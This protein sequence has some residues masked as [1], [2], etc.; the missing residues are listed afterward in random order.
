[1]WLPRFVQGDSWRDSLAE[2]MRRTHARWLTRALRTTP[3]RMH[4]IPRRRVDEGGFDRLMRT[5]AGRAWADRWW[6]RAFDAAD[7]HTGR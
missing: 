6:E 2:S 5:R 1:M 4:R 3:A 7:E